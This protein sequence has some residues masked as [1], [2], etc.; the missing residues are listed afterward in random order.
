MNGAELLRLVD[1]IHRER[2]IDPEILIQGLEA[3]I[4]SAVRKRYEDSVELVVRIDRKNGE[5]T[6]S[7]DGVAINAADLGR[8]AAQTA[9]Q[10]IIQKVREAEQS[11]VMSEYA[12]RRGELITGTVVRFE[13]DDIVVT[14]GKTEG[15]LRR[16]DR[17]RGET[18]R[19][20]DRLRAIIKDVRVTGA[21]V[22]VELSRTSEDFIR[23]LF[24]LE[25]PEIA[26]G[27]LEIKRLVREPGYRTKM[28]VYSYDQ[29][30]DCVGACVGV[31]GS[32][33]RNVTDELGGEKIDV[34]R[35]S[36][37]AEVLIMNALKPAEIESITL[38]DEA[39]QADVVVPEDFLSL[40]IGKKGQNVRLA[41]KLTDWNI[42]ILS[43]KDA[44]IQAAATTDNEI[45]TAGL[46]Q[47]RLTPPA[48]GVAPAPS[49]DSSAPQE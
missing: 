23:R 44:S 14:L 19:V 46:P 48:Q 29:R 27:T 41:T 21:R 8:I 47:D 43:A 7:K 45:Y 11:S 22:Q 35:W 40:A 32:R 1:M 28:A 49:A 15:V 13:R 34:I 31:R 9:K 30:V 3:A 36:E 12:S 5:L 6:A 42:N 33:I 2:D 37:E 38:H 39:R 18:P 17:I 10:V 4:E 16:T 24:E 20:G 26:E 25:V